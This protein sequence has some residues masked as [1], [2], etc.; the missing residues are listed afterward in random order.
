MS[1]NTTLNTGTGGDVIATDDFTTAKAQ[2]IKVM[3]GATGVDGG[4]VTTANPFPVSPAGSYFIASSGNTTTA[5]LAA[6]GT[7]TGTVES[8]YNQQ[9]I[10]ILLTSDQPGTLTL[11]QYIDSGA[12][13][14]AHT[15]VYTNTAGSPLS[16]AI[17]ANGNYFKA[18]YQ[19]TGASTTTTLDLDVAYGTIDSMTNLG[20]KPVALLE[21]N[22]AAI[23]N[24][25]PIPVQQVNTGRTYLTFFANAAAAGT[26]GTET[27]IS[28]SRTTFDGTAAGTAAAS[29][30]PTSGKRFR[31]TSITLASRGNATATAQVTNFSLRVNSGGAVTT[32]SSVALST[33]T[34]TPATA[35]AWDR[36][37]IDF[38]ADGPEL[39]G[40]GTLQWGI[41]ANAVYTTNAPTWYVEV[42]GY[43][44]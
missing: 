9:A 22:K 21:Y 3:L 31:I 36:W 39:V 35:S 42:T 17:V 5:Q 14:L 24:A 43:E 44:Y 27:A 1:A 38:G 20:N 41:T 18:T 2:R 23:S 28:I 12:T 29:Q 30:T 34:A 16:L 13:K 15:D 26:T 7:F 37:F 33:G 32:S 25:N 10:S 11:Y 8:V 19:N 40:N 6:S 4:N